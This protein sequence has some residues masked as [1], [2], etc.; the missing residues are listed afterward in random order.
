MDQSQI[1]I[2]VLDVPPGCRCYKMDF[3]IKRD[4]RSTNTRHLQQTDNDEAPM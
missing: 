4:L 1:Q 2:P 3:K